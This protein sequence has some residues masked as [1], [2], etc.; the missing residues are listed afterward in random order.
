M[1]NTPPDSQARALA[2]NPQQSFAVS[3]PAGSG[4]TGL[5]TQRVLALLAECE[6]PENVLAITF[7]K[8]AAAEMQERILNA[9]KDAANTPTPPEDNF[10]RTTWQ[11][12]TQVLAQD[13]KQKWQLLQC[14]NRLRITTIDSFCRQLSQQ[15]PLNH[16]LGSAPEI[17]DQPE[18]AYLQAARDTLDL[19]EGDNDIQQDLVVLIQHFNNQLDTIENLLVRLLSKRDQWLSALFSA[20]EKRHYLESVLQQVII[21][22]LQKTR[23]HLLPYSS[24]LALLADFAANNLIANEDNDSSIKHCLGLTA[25]PEADLYSRPEWQGITELLLTKEAKPRKSITKNQGFPAADKSMSAEQKAYLKL[26]KDNIKSLLTRLADDPVAIEYLATIQWL[27]SPEYTDAQWKL[28][29]SLTRILHRLVAQ[30]Y[31][32]F[33]EQGKTDY[34]EITLAA[35]DALGEPD[36]PSDL[37][38]ILEYRLQHILVDEFQDTSSTQLSLL[39]RLTA[40]WQTGDGHTLFVVGDAMQSCYRFR[41]ANVGLFLDIRKHGLGHIG[42]TPLDLTVNFRSSHAV[43]DWVNTLFTHVFPKTDSTNDGAVSYQKAIAYAQPG[44]NSHISLDIVVNTQ[45]RANRQAEAEQIITHIKDAQRQDSSQTIAIL[46]RSRNQVPV[47]T[48]ALNQHKINYRATEI[49]PLA[50]NMVIQDLLSLTRA[51]LYPHDRIAWLS[52]LRAPWC[53]LDMNDLYQVANPNDKDHKSSILTT[54]NHADELK[55]SNDGLQLLNHFS[56]VIKAAFEKQQRCR[57]RN[58]IEGTWHA[59][60][61]DYLL[62]NESDRYHAAVFFD[63]LNEYDAGGRILVWQ[64]FLSA[65]NALYSKPVEHSETQYSPVEI[66]TIHKSKG[67]EFDT[68]IIPGLDIIQRTDDNELLEWMEIIDAQQHRDLLISPV[69][70]T[71]NENDS[72]YHYIKQ[73]SRKKQSLEADRVFY[74]GCTR[75]VSHLHLIACANTVQADK[76]D[77]V[78]TLNIDDI[79]IPSNSS[80]L[81]T[82]WPHLKDSANIIA[83]E[84]N[85]HITG[86]E[87]TTHPNIIFRRPID[88]EIP[89]R[90]TGNLLAQYRPKPLKLQEGNEKNRASSELLLQRHARYFGT[91]LHAAIAHVT[92]SPLAIDSKTLD[93]L[94]PL[95]QSK[96]TSLGTP[97]SLAEEQSRKINQALTKML[98]SPCGQWLLDHSHKDSSCEKVIYYQQQGEIKH[99]IIDRTFMVEEGNTQTRWIIDYKSSEPTLEQSLDDFIEHEVT[100]YQSQLIH[101]SQ[102]FKGES[103]VVKL[104]LYFPLLDHFVEL[105]RD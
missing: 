22:H 14:P 98:E 96:L 62:L 71:G 74:V 84:E 104:A 89:A 13:K 18:A 10:K 38:L 60:G 103:S 76:T 30:L 45:Q 79:H 6:Q 83:L 25:L 27:P 44:Q 3:A 31:V 43:V 56:K 48:H 61:G 91:V 77:E 17:L 33:Q 28:L 53:G 73:Q 99:S 93:T 105:T 97:R 23:E 39:E 11:L 15:S 90:P 52:I 58:W 94:K 29:D 67:L 100:Q 81:A 69:H 37:S 19:L 1:M 70:A 88:W 47:I 26:Q 42:L 41:N 75:A 9:L 21:E 35:L 34:I 86:A 5:L 101:Y 72:I 95:W 46:V 87:E 55:L 20:K 51:L 24:D 80:T 40:G 92:L 12:A 49:D 7:T 50:N 2:L 65:I 54:I 78:E 102:F 57:L 63:L 68:V 85:S 4:K 8:K 32:S 16:H 64:H 82:I 66:M 59:L 36:K